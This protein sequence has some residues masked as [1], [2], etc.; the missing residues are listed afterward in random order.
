MAYDRLVPRVLSLLLLTEV[1]V[2]AIAL[3]GCGGSSTTTVVTSGE[4]TATETTTTEL[5]ATID[6]A[7]DAE[8]AS[9]AGDVVTSMQ[10]AT[11]DVSACQ[12]APCISDA[13]D[14]TRE[15]LDNLKAAMESIDGSVAEPCASAVT[16]EIAAIDAL[17]AGLDELELATDANVVDVVTRLQS[18][19]KLFSRSSKQFASVC[20]A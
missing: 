1:A 9:A 19:A 7:A 10:N 14:Q 2:L 6:A 20:T 11:A 12:D 13:F 15:P 4:S 18:T 5:P 16:A 3:A 17:Q 8:V